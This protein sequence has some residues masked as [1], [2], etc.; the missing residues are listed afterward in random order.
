MDA[1]RFCLLTTFYPPW[2]FGG[3]ALMVR[4]LARAL[5]ARGDSVTV[6]CSAGAHR[7][8]SRTRVAPPDHES[9]IELIALDDGAGALIGR[10]LTGRPLGA[11]APIREVLDRGFDVIHFHNPSLLGAPR[12]LE[13]G[14]GLKLYTT[15]EQWLLCPSHVLWRRGTPWRPG[16][17]VC[18]NPPCLS[19]EITHGRPPQ[20][21]RRTSLL[22]RC[23]AE[24]DALIAPSRTVARLH[25]RF[26]DVV[27][28]TVLPN[29][30]SPGP[31]GV[32]PARSGDRDGEPR[33]VT[34]SGA[35]PTPDEPFFL[36]VG[37][38]EPIKGVEDL[39]EAF[40]S[41]SERLLVVGD[42]SAAGRLRRA[43]RGLANV[44]FT[45]ELPHSA[46]AE[47]Y[48][49]ALA[50][51]VPTRGHE[52]MPLVLP[53]AFSQG[54]PAI[55]RRFGMLEEIASDSG[56]ALTYASPAELGA[57]LDRLASDRRLRIALGEQA[58]AAAAGPYSVEA[59]LRGYFSLIGRLAAGRGQP[60]LA[61]AAQSAADRFTSLRPASPAGGA[62]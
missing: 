16:G 5:A 55:V 46:L 21:W 34:G 58:R 61:G 20:P 60:G 59:H 57:A 29:F 11:E 41:R 44:N 3:D 45:G 19:C 8:L 31:R 1:L 7:V 6:L 14:E 23:L 33:P 47:L 9:G 27:P 35:T 62:E 12:L 32:D 30:A 50:L 54:T 4:A 52:S 2:S 51:V 36:Y 43:A 18:E 38:L 37:R 22:R 15:H 56:A 40:R 13:L 24:L 48:R 49:K 17:R 39:I 26:E 42:G 25:S 53:E 28:I 10:Y